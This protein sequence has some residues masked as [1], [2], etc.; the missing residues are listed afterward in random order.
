MGVREVAFLGPNEDSSAAVPDPTTQNP[1][2]RK[3]VAAL[4]ESEERYR[5]LVEGVRRY[6]IFLVDPKGIIMDGGFRWVRRSRRAIT[7]VPTRLPYGFALPA[8]D[9]L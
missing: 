1:S 2:Y 9:R 8:G 5:M 4:A 7:A 6:A 3:V